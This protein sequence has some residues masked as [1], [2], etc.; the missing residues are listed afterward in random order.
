MLPPSEEPKR[1]ARCEETASRTARTSSMRCSSVGSLSL[2]TRSERPVPRLSKRISRENRGQ[3]AEKASVLGD[4]PGHFYI[5]DPARNPN[6]VERATA[7]DLVRDVDVTAFGLAGF[8]RLH[9]KIN[10]RRPR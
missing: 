2:D 4:L 7:D 8:R 3:P 5:R 10:L 6:K 9:A 1:A